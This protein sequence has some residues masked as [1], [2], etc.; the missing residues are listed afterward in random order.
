[1]AASCVLGI[2]VRRRPILFN[3]DKAARRPPD[4]ANHEASDQPQHRDWPQEEAPQRGAM[5]APFQENVSQANRRHVSG[6][7]QTPIV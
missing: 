5:V 3:G 7:S 6:T 4:R 2:A 1:M